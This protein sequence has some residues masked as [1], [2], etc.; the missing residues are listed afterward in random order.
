MPFTRASLM[1]SHPFDQILVFYEE[2]KGAEQITADGREVAR[3]AWKGTWVNVWGMWSLLA[4]KLAWCMQRRAVWVCWLHKRDCTEWRVWQE[5]LTLATH[6]VRIRPSRH[7]FLCQLFPTGQQSTET[8]CP[9]LA[10]PGDKVRSSEHKGS[11]RF[12][13]A[14]FCKDVTA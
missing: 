4:P 13:T 5:L 6:K 8:T 9:E 2:T 14:T 3:I 7:F 1:N 10:V 11:V 12:N